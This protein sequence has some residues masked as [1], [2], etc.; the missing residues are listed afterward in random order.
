[1]K[2]DGM[3]NMV[4]NFVRLFFCIE[5][6]SYISWLKTGRNQ[7]IIK[8]LAPSKPNEKEELQLKWNGVFIQPLK[9]VIQIENP[10]LKASLTSINLCN[11][12]RRVANCNFYDNK[13]KMDSI[14][15]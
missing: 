3:D 1:M 6:K 4:F 8:R 10:H 5:I 11:I 15:F 9:N 13:K 2:R 7:E 14:N 12:N